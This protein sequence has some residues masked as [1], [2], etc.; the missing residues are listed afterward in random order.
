MFAT[1]YFMGTALT[2][3]NLHARTSDMKGLK[4]ELW[5]LKVIRARCGSLQPTDS[6]S[7]IAVPL[8][9]TKPQ[10]KRTRDQG[11]VAFVVDKGVCSVELLWKRLDVRQNIVKAEQEVRL[12]QSLMSRNCVVPTNSGF[13]EGSEVFMRL[14]IAMR[15]KTLGKP[16]MEKISK[17]EDVGGSRA[18]TQRHGVVRYNP[19]YLNGSGHHDGRKVPEGSCNKASEY[20]LVYFVIGDPRFA[21]NSG[22]SLQIALGTCLDMK[23]RHFIRK[24]TDK[25]EEKPFKLSEDMLRACCERLWKC[26]HVAFKAAP[27]EALYV[28]RKWSF[29]VYW[30]RLEKF[31]L[32]RSRDV[33]ETDSEKIIQVKQRMQAVVIGKKELRLTDLIAVSAE[34]FVVGD[35]KRDSCIR[36]R[37]GRGV[38]F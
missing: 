6:R 2:W 38:R 32:T 12:F 19:R 10:W 28:G 27:F 30:A 36:F 33:Q 23:L 13:T 14:K 20:G 1:L 21:S 29:T 8:H 4:P 18:E 16:P 31:Q 15:L 35:Y 25:G 37:L 24:L 11:M 26:Y 34:E 7:S 3:W 5:N 22:W 9:G 17:S